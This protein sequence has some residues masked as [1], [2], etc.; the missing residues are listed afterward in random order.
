LFR[1]VQVAGTVWCAA[2]SIMAGIEDLMQRTRDG[3]TG[4]VLSGRVIGRSVN[5]VC[6]LHRAHGDEEHGFLG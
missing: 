4:Q 5:A 1:D 3:R 2:M 6:V